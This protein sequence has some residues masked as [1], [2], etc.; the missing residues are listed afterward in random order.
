MAS[1]LGRLA[2]PVPIGQRVR[3]AWHGHGL[4]PV[5]RD[6]DIGHMIAGIGSLEPKSFPLSG[7]VGAVIT[8]FIESG[9][10]TRIP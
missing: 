2:A 1:P 7:A 5:R 3:R 8:L 10:F 9:P 4:H 6:R